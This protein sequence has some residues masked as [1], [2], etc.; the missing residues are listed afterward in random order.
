MTVTF[1]VR[2]ALAA[3]L[4]MA[5]AA[6]IASRPAAAAT[7]LADVTVDGDVVTLGD[8][9]DGA[10]DLAARPVFRSPDPGVDGM[11]PARDAIE[12]A[13]AAG[14]DPDPTL[15]TS[16]RVIRRTSM[17]DAPALSRLVAEAV[18][19]R[20]GAPLD[21]LSVSFDA[22]PA[23]VPADASSAQ[24][25]R[26][27]TITWTEANGR[28]RVAF[29]VDTGDSVRRLDLGG[30]AVR[31]A[32]VAVPVRPIARGEIVGER[33]VVIERRD[34][35]SLDPG[36]I[37]DPAEIVGLAA[38]R[39]LRAGATVTAAM[40]E[41]PKIVRRGDIVT[42][43]YE[44]PGLALSARGRALADAAEGESVSVVN[45]Q[46]RRTV[47]GVAIGPDRV[48]IAPRRLHTAA[49]ASPVIE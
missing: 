13:R 39:S 20:S 41:E 15:L 29:L 2:F 10:G 28:F 33:D 46:S 7:L 44:T 18:A 1:L 47:E 24:P 16:V 14:L 36:A 48:R 11:L 34:R 38:R 37:V 30:I 49:V 32:E 25:V 9:F 22:T 42:L 40:L 35:S 21:E 17:I 26:I 4:A 31:T 12:A 5:I 43:V 19:A 45:E 23:T 27:D 8:L 6:L 3:V